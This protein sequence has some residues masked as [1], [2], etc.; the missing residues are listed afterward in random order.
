MIRESWRL[1]AGYET[2]QISDRGRCRRDGCIQAIRIDEYGHAC[3]SL[4]GGTP[5]NTSRYAAVLVARAFIGERPFGHIVWH[6][7]GDLENDDVENLSYVHASQAQT[8]V[9]KRTAK[10][11]E[12]RRKYQRAWRKRDLQRAASHQGVRRALHSGVLVKGPCEVCGEANV[13][14]HHHRGYQYPLAVQWLCYEHHR[15]RHAEDAK[16]AVASADN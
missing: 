16:E 9:K 2:Y 10:V 13:H 15:E 8:V 5:D 1:I 7:D 4:R 12:Q 6:G 14:A 11:W 3:V